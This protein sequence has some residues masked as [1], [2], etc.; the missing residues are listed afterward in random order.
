[1]T[2]LEELKAL[3]LAADKPDNIY[4]RVLNRLEMAALQVHDLEAELAD[5][6]LELED[7]RLEAKEERND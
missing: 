4:A 5:L 7:A 1:M 6:Y 3:N 2:L